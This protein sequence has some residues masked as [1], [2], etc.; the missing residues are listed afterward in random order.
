MSKRNTYEFKPDYAVIPGESLL[1]AIQYLGITQKEFAQRIDLTEQSLNRI[2]KGVQPITYET[3][4]KLEQVTGTSCEFWTNLEVNYQKQLQIQKRMKQVNVSVEWLKQFP[5]KELCKRGYIKMADDP[6]KQK[7]EVLSFFQTNSIKSFNTYV[8]STKAAA[9]GTAAFKTDPISAVTYIYMGLRNAQRIQT[10]PYNEAKFKAVLQQ[11]RAMTQALTKDFDLELQRLFASAGVALVYVPPIKRVPLSG[12]CKWVSPDKAMIIMNIRGKS[13][14]RFW[15]SLFHEAAHILLHGKKDIFISDSS[16]D[17]EEELEADK[18]AADFLIPEKYN[19]KIKE[20]SSD[21]ELIEMAN[22]LGIA[23][24]IVVGRYHHLTE[25][26]YTFKH[27]IRKL[28][29]K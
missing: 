6:V 5:V 22:E 12:V 11:A 25:Q 27:L 17:N 8:I 9:R 20:A 7:I 4:I 28:N 1:E 19:S 18:Y 3:A 26:W 15:F 13:E 16:P 29:W 21:E 10:E 24:G 14:D 23:V 2:L